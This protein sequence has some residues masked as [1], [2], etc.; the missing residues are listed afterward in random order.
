[1][2]LAIKKW[3]IMWLG[4]LWEVSHEA[5]GSRTDHQELSHHGHT[6]VTAPAGPDF[7]GPRGHQELRRKCSPLY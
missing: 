7:P 2:W 1:M 5:Q 6:Q 3:V 4:A